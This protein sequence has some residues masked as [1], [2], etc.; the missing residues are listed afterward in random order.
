M[1]AFKRMKATAEVSILFE[2]VR[3]MS[4]EFRPELK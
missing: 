3:L 2:G 1:G 4:V